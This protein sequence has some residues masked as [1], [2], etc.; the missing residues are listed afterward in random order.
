MPEICPTCGR[1]RSSALDAARYRFR[2]NKMARDRFFEGMAAGGIM[3]P[4]P[5]ARKPYDPADYK[6]WLEK[7]TMEMAGHRPWPPD[8]TLGA[9]DHDEAD[10]ARG[11]RIKSKKDRKKPYTIESRL[12]PADKTSIVYLCGLNEWFV[13]GRY[14]TEARRDQAYDILV[15]KSKREFRGWSSTE[16]RKV[17]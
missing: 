3:P 15:S 10:A 6:S 17:G 16:W 11:R 12:V 13:H 8:P 2:L 4:K 5:K 1:G 14:E 7:Q 9:F